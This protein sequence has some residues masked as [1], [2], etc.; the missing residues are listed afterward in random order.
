MPISRTSGRTLASSETQ[1]L[2]V[3]IATS[4][5]WSWRY[6]T[7][8]CTWKLPARVVEKLV[9]CPASSVACPLM[10]LSEIVTLPT[11]LPS[12]TYVRYCVNETGFRDALENHW[13]KTRSASTTAPI[14]IH[15][16]IRVRGAFGPAPSGPGRRPP[17]RS[18]S[19]I[20]RP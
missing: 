16:V 19:G 15:G 10:E 20:L 1:G 5:W 6:W 8:S 2:G 18:L 14:T 12:S 4:T 3:V 11:I 17:L 13:L 9:V 7:S